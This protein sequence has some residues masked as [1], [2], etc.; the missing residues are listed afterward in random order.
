MAFVLENQVLDQINCY[1]TGPCNYI[2]VK[3]TEIDIRA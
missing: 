2:L 1:W 3:N